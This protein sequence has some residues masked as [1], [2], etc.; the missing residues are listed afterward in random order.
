LM[1]QRELMRGQTGLNA[2]EK[3]RLAREAIAQAT[4]GVCGG[5]KD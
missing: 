3:A 1:G 4:A 5:E 2:E